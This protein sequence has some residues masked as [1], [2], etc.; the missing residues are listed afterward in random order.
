MK[1]KTAKMLI[2]GLCLGIILLIVALAAM[3]PK[4]TDSSSNETPKPP[5]PKIDNETAASIATNWL[6]NNGYITRDEIEDYCTTLCFNPNDKGSMWVVDIYTW[7]VWYEI[8]IDGD[9]GE[10]LHAERWPGI[11]TG[12]SEGEIGVIYNKYGT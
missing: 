7:D 8:D 11:K 2:G 1:K 5:K 9:T 3:P 12:K 4:T 6:V 10:V